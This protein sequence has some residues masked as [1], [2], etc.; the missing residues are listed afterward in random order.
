VPKIFT[1]NTSA[2]YWR[3]DC[4]LIHTDPLG[5]RDVEPPAEERIYLIAGHQHGSGVAAETDM[6][7][8]GA[9]AANLFTMVD[10]STVVR[11]FL[12]NLDRWV[13]QAIEPPPSAFPRLT[14]GTAVPRE[15]VLD[16]FATFPSM[17]LLDPEFMPRLPRLEL[18]SRSGEGSGDLAV[19]TG[20]P[21]PSFAPA[22]DDDGNE[23]VG[24]RLPDITVPV[25]THT[26][27][28]ARHPDTGGIGQLLDMQGTTLPFAQTRDE[29]LQ[30]KDPRLSIAER[31]RDREDYVARVRA[32]A[33]VLV[34]DGYL[35]AE[36]KELAVELAAERF[37]LLAPQPA[38]V[39]R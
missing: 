13:S 38:A 1:T 22:V 25:G 37:D 32:A 20:E 10:G 31:Y 9:R 24:I 27:W 28:V 2:E 5:T 29:R 11:A 30:R 7:P 17:S 18:H 33:E 3:S 19:A 23:V 15:A 35:L 16:R 14:D 6:T 21:Y 26:G 8:I 12:I 34:K 4:S 36:D 39:R